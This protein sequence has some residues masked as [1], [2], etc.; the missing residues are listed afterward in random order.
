M[1]KK[2]DIIVYGTQG[3]CKI[4]DRATMPVGKEMRSYFVL[5]PVYDDR[6]T[7]YVPVDNKSLLNN[8]K[9]LLSK[10]EI[11]E[12]IDSAAADSSRWISDDL[13]RKEYC[14]NVIKSGDR[15]ELMQ[16]ISMLYLH[17]KTLKQTKKHFHI[18]DEKYLREAERLINDEFS[19]TLNIPREDVPEYI[20][21]RIEKINKQ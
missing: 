9:H 3:V 20:S 14:I 1:F 4:S 7:I 13:K 19:Y 10:E 12:L 11:N 5:T 18:S 16:L 6:A 21:S 15:K 8:M 17:Q 2:D